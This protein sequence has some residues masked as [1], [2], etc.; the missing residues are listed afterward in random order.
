[1]AI[2]KTV[3]VNLDDG[4]QP[5]SSMARAALEVATAYYSPALVNHCLRS[6]LWGAS[7]GIRHDIG[8]D[9]QL[10]FVSAMLRDTL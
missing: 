1:M 10:L 5:D 7:Y 4:P 2:G 6:Y 9:A 8:F 3:E